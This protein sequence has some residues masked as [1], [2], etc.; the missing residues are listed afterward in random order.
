[1]LTDQ[2]LQELLGFQTRYPVLSVYLSTDPTGGSADG[3]KLR[4]RSLLK[5]IALTDDVE[6]I[7]R[8]FDHEYNWSGRSVAVFSCTPDGF[9]RAYPLAIQVTDRVHMDK[10]PFV[11]PL[12][13]LLDDYG[14]YGVILVDKQGARLFYFHLGE[15]REQEGVLGENVKHV[16]RGGASTVPGRRGGIAG[17]TNRAEEVAERNMKEI[18]EFAAHFLAENNVRRVLIGG[19]DDN[20]AFFRSHLAK[21]WQSLVVGCFPMSMTAANIEVKERAMQIGREAELRREARLVDAVITGAAKG[22]GGVVSLDN[23]LQALRS[24]RVQTLV[25]EEGYH[26]PGFRCRGCG[27]LT[28]QEIHA[29][30]FCGKAFEHIPDAVE[31]V[32]YEVMKLGGDIEVLHGEQAE[33]LQKIGALLR[34]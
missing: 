25:V 22:K 26:A 16:K 31:M 7:L 23:T 13:D 29:C 15:L 17:R 5:D 34:Y 19:T 24:G 32:V 20:V 1:M 14:G 30:P 11:K 12:A 27:F 21:A 28:A 2:A 3:Y 10:Q 9:F 6:S 18:A 8:Y 4:L 33:E